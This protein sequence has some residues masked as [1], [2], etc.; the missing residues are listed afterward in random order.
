MDFLLDDTD[1]VDAF[2]DSDGNDLIGQNLEFATLGSVVTLKER[3]TKMIIAKLSKTREPHSLFVRS[4]LG[5]YENLPRIF[6]ERGFTKIKS[7][8]PDLLEFR[9]YHLSGYAIFQTSPNDL[10]KIYRKALPKI[11]ESDLPYLVLS[12]DRWHP[13]K[14]IVLSQHSYAIQFTDK[15][16]EL[17]LAT[18][19]PLIWAQPVPVAVPIEG[20]DTIWN[21]RPLFDPSTGQGLSNGLEYT[22]QK[23]SHDFGKLPVRVKPT[24][25]GDLDDVLSRL[26]QLEQRLAENAAY[27]SQLTDYLTDRDNMIQTFF[28][29]ISTGLSSITAQVEQLERI[30]KRSDLDS[31]NISVDLMDL[32]SGPSESIEPQSVIFEFSDDIFDYTSGNESTKLTM[33]ID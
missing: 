22:P 30:V 20:E 7:A 8:V 23:S 19:F 24:S 31:T 9:L 17:L 4:S 6:L 1:M 21:T 33:P 29:E 5:G 2:I 26:L 12:E 10:W 25:I 15:S 27:R 18:E 11:R 16:P 32:L 3:S 28:A 14:L 13:V